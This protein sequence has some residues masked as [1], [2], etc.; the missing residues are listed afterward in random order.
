MST[1][2]LVGGTPITALQN[3]TPQG[4]PVQ[5]LQPNVNTNSQVPQQTMQQTQP[6]NG[7]NHNLQH[8]SGVQQIKPMSSV[9]DNSF[10]LKLKQSITIDDL[11]LPLFVSI[12]YYLGQ[13]KILSRPLSEK[14]GN[15]MAVYAAILIIFISSYIFNK[16]FLVR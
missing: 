12:V 6:S 7:L 5:K 3:Q 13:K 11:Y 1:Q 16:Y 15:G 2:P 8:Q 14:F 10:L 4:P 9:T